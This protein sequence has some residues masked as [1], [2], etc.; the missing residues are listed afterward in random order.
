MDSQAAE[1]PR[2]IAASRKVSRL[3]WS[4]LLISA[5]IFIVLFLGVLGLTQHHVADEAREHDLNDASE[6]AALV[7]ILLEETP[8]TTPTA[9]VLE[10]IR[11]AGLN[12]EILQGNAPI[13]EAHPQL[14]D[15]RENVE[16]HTYITNPA[17]EVVSVARLIYPSQTA[18]IARHAVQIYSISTWLAGLLLISLIWLILHLTVFRRINSL[19]DLLQGSVPED[20][21]ALTGDPL[22]DLSVVVSR[23][24]EL[25]QRQ[26]ERNQSLLDAHE[27]IFCEITRDGSI[28]A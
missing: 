26:A 2:E 11:D 20:K 13:T 28:K 22:H 14:S 24:L 23:R 17:G 6:G 9:E 5:S 4:I 21:L 19:V 12:L 10:K 3:E 1:K 16:A 15:S 18:Q 25:L 7:K 27:E 8:G